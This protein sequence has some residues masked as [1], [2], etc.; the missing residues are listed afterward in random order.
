QWNHDVG[1]AS[2]P[3]S[4]TDLDDWHLICAELS[5]PPDASSASGVLFALQTYFALVAKLIALVILEGATGHKLVNKLA[6]SQDIFEAFEDL[7]SGAITQ[8]TGALN[9]IE[10][11]VLSWYVYERSEQLGLA[12]RAVVSLA[13]EY[14]A[15]IVEVTPLVVRDVLK[16]LYQR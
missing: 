7:E 13:E 14:S 9:V 6:D 11:G 4:T 2:G 3:F 5:L 8:V 15:E 12:L 1:I 10:P 16:D